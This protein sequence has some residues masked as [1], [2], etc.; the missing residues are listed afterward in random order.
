MVVV[1]GSSLPQSD[2]SAYP[3]QVLTRAQIELSSARTLPELV[4]QMPQM[5]N[6]NVS[7]GVVGGDS[8]GF[9]G[10]SLHN[11]GEANTL[12][13]LNGHRVACFAGQT[14]LGYLA[15]VDLSTLPMVVLRRCMAP[16]PWGASSM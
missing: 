13:L 4:R 9:A 10:A 2:L 16:M 12:V 6:A 14:F 7:T 8:Y 15:G 1:T 3:A 11:Q 5:L